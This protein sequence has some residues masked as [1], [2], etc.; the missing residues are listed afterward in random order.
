[1]G[2]TAPTRA[3]HLARIRSIPLTNP[4]F[5]SLTGMINRPSSRTVITGGGPEGFGLAAG[6][7]GCDRANSASA[8]AKIATT[9][10]M[11]FLFIGSLQCK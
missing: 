8:R 1:M 6:F 10:N 9:V 7:G 3:T 11:R 4:V 2:S 5:E